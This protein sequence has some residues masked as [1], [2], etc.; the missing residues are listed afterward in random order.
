MVDSIRLLLPC[1]VVMGALI[2]M[3][4][5]VRPQDFDAGLD[6]G[7]AEYLSNCADCHGADGKGKGPHS[8]MLKTRPADL[9]LLS[10]NNHGV[11][12]ISV[13]YRLIDGR[14]S[15]RNHISDEM[16]IWGCRQ[17]NPGP[18][19][20]NRHRRKQAPNAARKNPHANSLEMFLNLP[21]DPEQTIE[22]RIMSIIAYLSHIQAK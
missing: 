15:A 8:S 18:V 20:E 12:P 13:V 6:A 16:P 21:C 10:K 9:T 3:A 17:N 11:F 7:K 22:R 2:G 14:G 1:M 4:A 19:I 5:A